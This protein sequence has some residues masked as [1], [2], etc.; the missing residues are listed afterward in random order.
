MSSV[1]AC[2]CPLQVIRETKMMKQDLGDILG[3]MFG[4]ELPA[5]MV[6]S[7]PDAPS[8]EAGVQPCWSSWFLRTEQQLLV[9]RC[10]CRPPARSSPLSFFLLPSPGRYVILLMALFSIYTG[11][12]YNEM[13]SVGECGL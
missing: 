11:A 2:M 3:M 13:F 6:G 9:L 7:E 10:T 4:G 8:C 12:I 5:A 1:L